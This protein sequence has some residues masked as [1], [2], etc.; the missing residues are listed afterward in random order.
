[1]INHRNWQLW[2][3]HEGIL[4]NFQQQIALNEA[5]GRTIQKRLP[6]NSTNEFVNVI[7]TFYSKHILDEF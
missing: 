6:N 7:G 5:Y 3:T 1:M 2:R 4:C